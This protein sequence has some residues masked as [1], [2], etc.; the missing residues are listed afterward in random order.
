MRFYPFHVGDYAAHTQ[1]LDE[2][3]DLAYR[4]M[5]DYVYLNEIN[6]P[7]SVDEI[8]R[9]IRMRTHCEGIANVLR[10]F[11][12]LENGEWTNNRAK[13]EIDKYNEK[14][15]KAKQ[16]A[17]KRWKKDDA[18][19]LRTHCEGNANQEP[20]TKNQEPINNNN[21]N[22]AASESFVMSL[23]WLPNMPNHDLESLCQLRGITA[24]D[25]LDPALLDEFRRY[26]ASRGDPKTDAQ[27]LNQWIKNLSRQQ[28]FLAM[29]GAK[30]KT[31]I[32]K[33]GARNASRID[34]CQQAATEYL[35]S[36]GFGREDF[37]KTDGSDGAQVYEQLGNA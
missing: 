2:I 12:T 37:F 22:T 21:N 28:Q 15:D 31:A 26:W 32:E 29:D 36:Q 19:A 18:N 34:P 1:H 27:W 24:V 11:F 10:E 3:E 14:S 13:I 8:G 33:Q 6:L 23:D 7:E 25:P 30:L 5:L 16:S 35:R 20:R 9:L 17:S 4:R